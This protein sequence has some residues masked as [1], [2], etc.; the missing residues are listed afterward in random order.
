SLVISFLL[1][2]YAHETPIYKKTHRQKSRKIQTISL[3]VC[4]GVAALFGVAYYVPF[5]FLVQF[6]PSISQL[7]QESILL[8][9]N[10]ALVVYMLALLASGIASDK[11]GL[12]QTMRMGALALI[13]LSP[14]AL[15]LVMNNEIWG[16]IIGQSLLA[17]AAGLFIGPSHALMLNLFPP[18]LRYQAVGSTYT[19]AV[20]IVGGNT[21]SLLRWFY[22]Q[23]E[24]IFPVCM[25][26]LSWGLIVWVLLSNKWIMTRL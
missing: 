23:T 14:L 13:C 17:I 19:L 4:F 11:L 5:V 7:P 16:F 6:I 1:M 15:S 25:W 3:M 18:Q 8:I 9:T 10:I 12:K 22:C 26:V 24:S 21:P 2:L 20:T